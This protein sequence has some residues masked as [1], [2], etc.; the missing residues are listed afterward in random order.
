VTHTTA[1][2]LVGADILYCWHSWSEFTRCGLQN[3]SSSSCCLDRS[4]PQ[5]SRVYIEKWTLFSQ[6]EGH[7]RD[8][9]QQFCLSIAECRYGFFVFY[10][11]CTRSRDSSGGI[12]EGIRIGQPTNRDLILHSSKIFR[13]RNVHFRLLPNFLFDRYWRLFSQVQ[14]GR[15]SKLTTTCVW[16]WV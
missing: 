6:G 5:P 16:C 15:G 8:T 9:Y 12:V 3:D 11:F 14:S 2:K 13:F 4:R 1:R 10:F 7:F